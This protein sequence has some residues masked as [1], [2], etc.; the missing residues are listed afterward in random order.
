MKISASSQNILFPV[1]RPGKNFYLPSLILHSFFG[2]CDNVGGLRIEFVWKKS[3]VLVDYLTTFCEEDI[4]LMYP[5]VILP[6]PVWIP[7]RTALLAVYSHYLCC[8]EIS[9]DFWEAQRFAQR[10][11]GLLYR[12]SAFTHIS[13]YECKLI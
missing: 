1:L 8:F 13:D 11:L 2:S 6:T 9:P 12:N 3:S 5:F 10:D 4:V 7:F